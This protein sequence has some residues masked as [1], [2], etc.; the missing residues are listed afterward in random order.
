M[1][2]KIQIGNLEVYESGTFLVPPED[3]VSFNI[4]NIKV[5]LEFKNNEKVEGVDIDT[6]SV[7]EQHLK[8][9]LTNFTSSLGSG[10]F[11]PFRLGTINDRELYLDFWI[12]AHGKS[13]TRE[14]VYTFYLGGPVDG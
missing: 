12:Y 8:I 7:N 3:N 5:S 11:Q 1:P 9:I 10:L 14:I 13:K 4:Q 2:I 6:E